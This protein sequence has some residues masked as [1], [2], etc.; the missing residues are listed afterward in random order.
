[1]K[2]YFDEAFHTTCFDP[3]RAGTEASLVCTCMM[4]GCQKIWLRALRKSTVG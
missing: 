4:F 1:M 2:R 3:T